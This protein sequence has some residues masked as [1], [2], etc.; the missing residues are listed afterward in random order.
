MDKQCVCVG[1]ACLD[2]GIKAQCP[3]IY[4]KRPSFS[5]LRPVQN[6]CWLQFVTVMRGYLT[7]LIL[8]LNLL[9]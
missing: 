3:L 2:A 4:D 7:S 8:Y 5:Q 9:G 6:V 1:S